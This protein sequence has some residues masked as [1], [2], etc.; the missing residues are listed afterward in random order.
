MSYV[1]LLFFLFVILFFYFRKYFQ[2]KV[3]KKRRRVNFKKYMTDILLLNLLIIKYEYQNK[4]ERERLWIFNAQFNVVFA[5][6]R[7]R[8]KWEQIVTFI[9]LTKVFTRNKSSDSINIYENNK[10]RN[11]STK[12]KKSTIIMSRQNMYTYIYLSCSFSAFNTPASDEIW[13]V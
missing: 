13:C 9:H 2:L 6:F 4:I 10:M 7:T 1:F 8:S 11:C 5:T 3:K 12:K